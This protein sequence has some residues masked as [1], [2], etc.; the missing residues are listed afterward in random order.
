MTWINLKILI[1]NLEQILIK[2][3]VISPC[4]LPSASEGVDN[5]ILF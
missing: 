3:R 2:F 1:T 5:G 4:C